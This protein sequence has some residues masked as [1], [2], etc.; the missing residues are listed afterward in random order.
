MF[1]L[2]EVTLEKTLK[3]INLCYSLFEKYIWIL[4]KY[5]DISGLIEP[6]AVQTL[7]Q[8]TGEQKLYKYKKNQPFLSQKQLQGWIT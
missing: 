2:F 4:E 1:V 7:A 8:A 6:L 3:V 5:F